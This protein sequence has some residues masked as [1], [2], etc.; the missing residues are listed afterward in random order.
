M[1]T[2]LFTDNPEIVAAIIAA[3]LAFPL[4]ILATYLTQVLLDRRQKVQLTYSKKIETP[5][6]LSKDEFS[7]KLRITYQNVQIR[8]IYFFNL[9]VANTGRKVIK[10]Q[11]FTCL[12][13]EGSNLIDPSFPRISTLPP[14]EV[15]PITRDYQIQNSNEIRFVI[16]NIGPGQVINIDFLT[17]GNKTSEFQAIFRK[18]ND[19]SIIEGDVSGIPDLEFHI[20]RL[21]AGV[22]IYWIIIQAFSLIPIFGTAIGAIIGLPLIFGALRSLKPV[23]SAL[24]RRQQFERSHD[25]DIS[26]EAVIGIAVAGDVYGDVTSPIPPPRQVLSAPANQI[27]NSQKSGTL[28]SNS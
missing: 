17:T 16:E 24:L 5:V 19:I 8:N 1:D 10:N 11:A 2:K 23:I 4:G 14:R 18:D 21:V 25:Q 12:F 27:D 9:R 13:S 6:I 22:I 26:G 7:D 3:I 20:Q 15:G 28:P